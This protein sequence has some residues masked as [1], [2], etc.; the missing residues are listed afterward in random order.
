MEEIKRDM[1]PRLVKDLGMGYFTEKSKHKTK[2]GIYECQYCG[3]EFEGHT[4]NIKSGTAKSCGCQKYK[5]REKII[6]HGLRKHRL[7]KTWASMRDRCL[8]KS[9]IDYINYGGRGIEIC[10]RWLSIDNFIEDM[11][12]SYQEGLSLDR[13]DINGNY[14]SNN[15]RWATKTTQSRNTRDIQR[16]NTS[17]YRGVGW[18]KASNTWRVR[19][20][21]NYTTIELGSYPTALEGA[22]AYE[23]YVRLNKL[24]HNFTPALLEEEVEALYKQEE[25]K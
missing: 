21:V 18:H 20:I 13:I 15:C 19:I 24:E 25:T 17:G 12:P 8:N 1:T 3:K 14:E 6:K 23:T 4:Y 7:Y 2:L 9:G 10:G 22:K 11:Y 16:N 5:P